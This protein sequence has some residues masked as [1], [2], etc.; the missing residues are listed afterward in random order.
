MAV[1][2]KSI[3]EE[4]TNY[5]LCAVIVKAVKEQHKVRHLKIRHKT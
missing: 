1:T 4:C 5:Y 3:K 2:T